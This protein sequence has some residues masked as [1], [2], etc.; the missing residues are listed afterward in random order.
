MEQII[1]VFPT[2]AQAEAAAEEARRRLFVKYGASSPRD[3]YWVIEPI[4]AVQVRAPWQ[5]R[6]PAP[7][8]RE[9]T[10][11]KDLLASV[12]AWLNPF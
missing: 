4:N 3:K 10:P 5:W 6:G 2:R 9:V 11:P 1:A 12:E 7:R 8:L